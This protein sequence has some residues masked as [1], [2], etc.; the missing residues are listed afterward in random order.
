MRQFDDNKG[1]VWRL[2]IN[3]AQVKR[4]RDLLGVNLCDLGHGDLADR[5]A[6]DYCLLANIL[7]V[8]VMD[9]ADTAGVGDVEFGEA[10]CGDSI[11]A[12]QDA[13]MRELIDFFPSRR[14]AIFR[15]ALAVLDAMTPE[16]LQEF[17]TRTYTDY[18]SSSRE[19]SGLSRGGTPLANSCECV[20]QPS[21]A[22][23][24]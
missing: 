8:L 3:V 11:D 19:S 18:V 14:R 23:G 1:R 7:F 9:Q 2:E 20:P 12:A 21:G 22:D 4:V 13:F 16:R 15:A 5:L 17:A 10:L 6:R 24:A